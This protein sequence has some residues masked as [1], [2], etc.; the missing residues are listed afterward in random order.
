MLIVLLET[1][2]YMNRRGMRI[3]KQHISTM[4]IWSIAIFIMD[5]WKYLKSPLTK[6]YLKFLKNKNDDDT[7]MQL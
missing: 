7:E 2:N 4:S 5:Y 6:K 3:S 1:P